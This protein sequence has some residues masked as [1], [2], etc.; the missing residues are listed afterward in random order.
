VSWFTGAVTL[1]NCSSPTWQISIKVYFCG[2]GKCCSFNNNPILWDRWLVHIRRNTY[3]SYQSFPY[4]TS[5][6]LNHSYGDYFAWWKWGISGQQVWFSQGH[7]YFRWNLKAYW[8]IFCNWRR[9]KWFRR[10]FTIFVFTGTIDHAPQIFC[11]HLRE[12]MFPGIHWMINSFPANHVVRRD[13]HEINSLPITSI[14]DFG[15]VHLFN[16]RCLPNLC[17]FSVGPVGLETNSASL[18]GEGV[19]G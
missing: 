16:L 15:L 3:G 5:R 14:V 6:E 4:G 17:I 7:L 10:L 1:L 2:L 18:I 9:I 12:R 8:A 13:L 11:G 19:S